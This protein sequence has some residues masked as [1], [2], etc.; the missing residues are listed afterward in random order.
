[1]YVEL[2]ASK[3][4]FWIPLQNNTEGELSRMWTCAYNKPLHFISDN[5]ISKAIGKMEND[6]A[7][8]II[9]YCELII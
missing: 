8:C 5:M 6:N 2:T 9:W 1:M 7:T 4:P 3:D